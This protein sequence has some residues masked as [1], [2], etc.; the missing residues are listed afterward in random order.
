MEQKTRFELVQVPSE[1]QLAFKDN[2]AVE[3][4]SVL[5]TNS[6][7]IKIAN[8]LNEIKKALK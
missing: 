4:E 7:L 1:F 2:E 6:L 8:D 5:D 3:E